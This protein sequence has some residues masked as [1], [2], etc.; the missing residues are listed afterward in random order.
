M[1]I[2]KLGS[3]YR[4]RTQQQSS[5][6]KITAARLNPDQF[7]MLEFFQYGTVDIKTLDTG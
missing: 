1:C 5:G 3:G 4:A 6:Y 2:N 7:T